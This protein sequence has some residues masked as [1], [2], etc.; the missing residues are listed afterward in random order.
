MDAHIAVGHGEGAETIRGHL[1]LHQVK[2]LVLL[3]LVERHLPASAVVVAGGVGN[4][5]LWSSFHIDAN[6][7]LK[8][9]VMHGDD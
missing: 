8:M 2:D 9:G 7:I 4:H 5:N 3:D 1:L 6:G